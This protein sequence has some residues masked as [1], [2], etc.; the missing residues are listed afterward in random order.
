MLISEEV[1]SFKYNDLYSRAQ[2]YIYYTTW[3][4]KNGEPAVAAIYF[5]NDG[6]H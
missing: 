6:L 5:W 4:V 3:K 1:F 2:K